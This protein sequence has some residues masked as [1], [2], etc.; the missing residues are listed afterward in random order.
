MIA[1][2]FANQGIVPLS[3]PKSEGISEKV[4]ATR[5]EQK[6]KKSRTYDK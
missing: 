3:D 6:Q 2:D 5:G 4:R 1:G